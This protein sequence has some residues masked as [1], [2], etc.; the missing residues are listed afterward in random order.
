M[1]FGG[2]ASGLDTATIIDQLVSIARRPIVNQ[3]VK[4]NALTAR[5]TGLTQLNTS[6]GNL[7]ARIAELRD[8]SVLGARTVSMLHAT[9][10]SGKIIATPSANAAV[11]KYSVEVVSLATATRAS[12]P[13]AVGAAINANAGMHE[14]GF[15]V[16]VTAGTFSINGTQFTVVGE[17][18]TTVRSPAAL[19]STIDLGAPLVSAGLTDPPTG[20]GSFSINGTAIAY[21]A[22]AD[23][24]A[25]LLARVNASAAGV[26]ASWDSGAKQLVLTANTPGPGAITLSDDTGN[27]LAKTGLLGATQTDGTVAHTLNDVIGMI[28][29]AGI[30]VTATLE[31]DASG[32]PNLLQLTAGSVIQLGQGGDTSNFLHAAHLLESPPDM[33]RASVR[34]LG[35]AVTS[36]ALEDARFD[37]A[38]AQP[39]GSFTINGVA[40]AYDAAVDSL[41]NVISRINQSNAGVVATYDVLQDRLRLTSEATGSTSIALADVS[42]NFLA[43]TGVQAATQTLGTNASYR[44][45]GGA[46][47]YSTSNTVTSAVPGVSLQLRDTTTAP[48]NIEVIADHDQIAQRLTKFVEQYNSTMSQLATLT[49]YDPVKGN[50]G[51]LFGDSGAQ[52]LTQRLRSL[53]VSPGA[54]LTGD[55]STLTAVGLNFGAVGS[56]VGST[57]TLA[58]DRGKFDTAMQTDAEGVRKLLAGFSASA[59]LATANGAVTAI[60]GKPATA[61]DSGSY[62]IVTT[63]GGLASVTFTPDDGSSPVVTNT[64]VAP[65]SVNTTLIPGIS[66]QFPPVLLDAEDTITISADYEGVF[67]AMDEFVQSFTRSGGVM[68]S[69]NTEIQLRIDDVN[70]QITRIE[71][72]AGRQRESLIRRF[73]TL[74]TTMARLQSQ[75]QSLSQL[76]AQLGAK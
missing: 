24:I 54:G 66:I 11:G 74:E 7:A 26:T 3:Q 5:Q 53:I 8:T 50:H 13:Q 75:Q 55:L 61:T 14:A 18:A 4:L 9:A 15:E 6:L 64:T 31:N 43:A 65:G 23:S 39:S 41:A 49:K 37:T 33:T 63:A 45:D 10:D 56:A 30:G 28:N 19:G 76:V 1:F 27:F 58:F 68:T 62:S 72:R 47:Q 60:T 12:S 36:V 42:G 29:G 57:T 2:F 25:V 67:K 71:E 59:T 16:P 20:S 51:P 70:D 38:L 17:S 73:A 22:D 40:I 21:D 52:A 46:L 32:R 34:G 48:V 69:R 35:Q 44:V